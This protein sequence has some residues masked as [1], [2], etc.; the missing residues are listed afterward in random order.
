[1]PD[2]RDGL[3]GVKY[4]LLNDVNA[5]MKNELLNYDWIIKE[6]GLQ[7]PKI[8]SKSVPNL[9]ETEHSLLNMLAEVSSEEER[10]L[11]VLCAKYETY[12]HAENLWT[13]ESNA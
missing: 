3:D 8:F 13:S 12:V 1:M 2:Y 10:E 9:V 7:K 4:R 11:S 6:A 5:L